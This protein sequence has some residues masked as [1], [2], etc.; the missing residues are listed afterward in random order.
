M[1]LH[2]KAVLIRVL[3]ANDTA[4]NL[5]L[6]SQNTTSACL[7]SLHMQNK[8]K[9]Q[10]NAQIDTEPYLIYKEAGPSLHLITE[11]KVTKKYCNMKKQP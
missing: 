2:C 11:Y 3:H 9:R 4:S 7:H 8:F 1:M 10:Q 5:K 6:H